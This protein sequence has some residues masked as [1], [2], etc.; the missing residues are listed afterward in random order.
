METGFRQTLK[1]TGRLIIKLESRPDPDTETQT[2]FSEAMRE[3][4]G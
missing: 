1:E 4:S 3:Q 2:L